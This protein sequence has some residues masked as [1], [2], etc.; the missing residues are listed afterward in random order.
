MMKLDHNALKTCVVFF[1]G[2]HNS[3]QV[4]NLVQKV[5]TNEE[6]QDDAVNA[7]FSSSTNKSLKRPCPTSTTS[8]SVKVQH[9]ILKYC[10]FC[11]RSCASSTKVYF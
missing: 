3:R 4:I 10:F 9:S 7:P 1:C 2:L 5:M 6:L 11:D 8:L